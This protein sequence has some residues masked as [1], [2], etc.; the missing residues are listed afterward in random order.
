MLKLATKCA[1]TPLTLDQ[2]YRAGFRHAELWLDPAILADWPIVLRH[3]RYYPFTYA[4]HFPN[5]LS[6]PAEALEQ[7]VALYRGLTA[8]CVIIHQPMFDR[9]AERLLQLEPRLVLAIENHKLSPEAF[10]Q[11]AERSPG[12][13]L[14]VEHLWKFTLKNGPLDALL[15]RLRVLLAEHGT[16]LR[17]VHMPGY[18]PGFEEHRPMYCAREMVQP[19]LSQLA[20]AGFEGLVVSEVEEKYQNPEELRMDVLLFE[21]WRRNYEQTATGHC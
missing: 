7:L 20:S 1:P 10:E 21:L 13:A 14:D 4:L 15:E 9:F 18:W 3:T 17:H 2:A 6:L 16:K 19:V 8:H 12:M 5:S 11:W